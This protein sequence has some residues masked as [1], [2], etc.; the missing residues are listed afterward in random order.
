MSKSNL[1]VEYTNDT[2]ESEFYS[3]NIDSEYEQDDYSDLRSSTI[4]MIKNEDIKPDFSESATFISSSL[5]RAARDSMLEETDK[6]FTISDMPAKKNE[7]LESLKEYR[8]ALRDIPQQKGFP[9]D[10]TWPSKPK[11]LDER[12]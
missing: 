7:D 6:Y 4:S 10:I 11:W 12:K 5:V 3:F 9:T 8:Q 1:I 2:G